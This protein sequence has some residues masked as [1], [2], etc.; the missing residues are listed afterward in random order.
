VGDLRNKAKKWAEEDRHRDAWDRRRNGF[1]VFH[2]DFD[3]KLTRRNLKLGEAI[4]YLMRVTGTRISFWRCPIR[5]L[6]VQYR[7]LPT[8][9]YGYAYGDTY[10]FLRFSDVEEKAEA[11]KVLVLDA[12]LRGIELYRGLPNER[13]DDEVQRIC[14]LLKAP[15]SISSDEWLR[16]LATLQKETQ[17]LLRTHEAALRHHLL[18]EEYTGPFGTVALSVRPRLEAIEGG[19]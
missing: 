12:I 8:T 14:W 7:K 13:F 18:G 6:A 19:R 1:T 4:R 5:G 10:M 17:P 3:P 2:F 16:M 11:K 9:T 15:P